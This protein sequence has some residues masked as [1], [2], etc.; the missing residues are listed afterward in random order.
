SVD[1]TTFQNLRA[2]VLELRSEN[3]DLK[4]LVEE[5][6]KERELIEATLRQRD[7]I[8]LT[9]YEK[10]RLASADFTTFQNLRAQVTELRSENDDLKLSVKELTKE[11]E[12]VEV[13]LRQR[14]EMV[15][16]QYEKMR[17]LEKISE[18]FHEV[19]Y[20]IDSDIFYDTQ[21]NSEK[22][23]ILSLQTQL[24][25]T[26]ELVVLLKSRETELTNL[27]KVY[28]VKESVLLEKIDQMKSQVSELLDKL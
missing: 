16:T 3:D 1:F 12:L 27:E 17:L 8:V 11:R 13:T 25:E 15:L 10:M 24:K 2:Q 9:Q 4:L 6:T 23:L 22:D 28:G 5:L 19:H 18:T 20:E 14:D 26:T 7:E 21:D